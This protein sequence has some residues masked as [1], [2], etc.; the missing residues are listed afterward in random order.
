[1]S[2][3]PAQRAPEKIPM[4]RE[5]VWDSENDKSNPNVEAIL[6]DPRMRRTVTN[7]GRPRPIRLLS[8]PTVTMNQ[9]DVGRPQRQGLASEGGGGIDDIYFAKKKFSCV[10]RRKKHH[11]PARHSS[12]GSAISED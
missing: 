1:M 6:L 7:H 8:S 10:A 5:S 12:W 11:Q 3:F 2:T 9:E 4:M